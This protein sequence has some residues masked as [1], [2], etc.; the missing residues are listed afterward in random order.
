M[1]SLHLPSV[2][3]P[4]S[5]TEQTQQFIQEMLFGQTHKLA[6]LL[7][8]CLRKRK[9]MNNNTRCYLLGCHVFIHH[10]FSGDWAASVSPNLTP[11]GLGC[12]S[13]Q[14]WHRSSRSSSKR[15]AST[16]DT[17]AGRT[18]WSHAL[19]NDR[20][21]ANQQSM[22]NQER[23]HIILLPNYSGELNKWSMW[24]NLRQFI[25]NNGEATT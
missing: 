11:A 3:L 4:I 12:S 16:T 19:G 20:S 13:R 2:P 6:N 21:V 22:T 23:H 15:K 7:Q 9:K 25:G 14:S 18:G 5:T 8:H 1:L 24:I 17:A 10:A